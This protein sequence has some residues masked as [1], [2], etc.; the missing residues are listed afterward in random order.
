MNKEQIIK[1]VAYLLGAIATAL[2]IAFGLSSCGIT[3][4][5][6]VQPKDGSTCTITIS[7]NQPTQVDI[8]ID[9]DVLNKPQ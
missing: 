8:P 1:A 7:T 6:I 9:A 3:R 4:A 2:L 5:A